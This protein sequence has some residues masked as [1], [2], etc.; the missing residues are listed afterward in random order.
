Y[1]EARSYEKLLANEI[2]EIEVA[3]TQPATS[4]TLDG[5]PVLACPGTQRTRVV[6]GEHQLVAT[7]PGFATRTIELV[8]LGG[9][10]QHVDVS[11]VPAGSDARIVHRWG[12]WMPWTVF[13]GGLV[14]VGFGA[15][16]ELKASADFA[17]FDRMIQRDCVAGCTTIDTSARDT[18]RLENRVGVGM[19][20]AGGAVTAVG[21]VLAY[22]NR[23]RTV[24][25][26]EVS[27]QPSTGG[28]VVT[29]SRAF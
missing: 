8:V 29:W 16:V 15:L 2:G 18:A 10:H 9:K 26:D 6:P 25:P 21:A 22:L 3:C 14:V 5:R 12:L 4:I 17:A 7:K 28:G 13:G 24:Y 19:L 20:V 23:A 11:L 1:A 27:V